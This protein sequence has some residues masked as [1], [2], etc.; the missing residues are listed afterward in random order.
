M[1]FLQDQKEHQV[2]IAIDGTRAGNR[3]EVIGNVPDQVL[4]SGCFSGENG[5]TVT[6]LWPETCFSKEIC[7]CF[8]PMGCE[9]EIRT[10]PFTTT[11]PGGTVKAADPVRAYAVKV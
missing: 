3:L 7:F 9:M 11:I 5:F 8:S 1:S 4:M 10:F 6:A 2:Q